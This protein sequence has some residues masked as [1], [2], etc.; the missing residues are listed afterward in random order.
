MPKIVNSGTINYTVGGTTADLTSNVFSTDLNVSYNASVIKTASPAEF[1]PD[2]EITCQITL[3]NTGY[4]AFCNL[5]AV[6]KLGNN[7]LKYVDG[8]E[9]ALLY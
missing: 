2:D 4:G 1:T 3:N 8:S 7:L 5:T 9:T 6:D